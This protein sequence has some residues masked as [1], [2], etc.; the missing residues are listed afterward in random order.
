MLSYTD[1]KLRGPDLQFQ[2]WFNVSLIMLVP[3]MRQLPGPVKFGAYKYYHAVDNK[4][5]GVYDSRSGPSLLEK[6]SRKNMED[7]QMYWPVFF[8]QSDSLLNEPKC[9]I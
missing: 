7:W 5:L 4:R 8:D 3:I 6:D 2:Q 9:G 1:K